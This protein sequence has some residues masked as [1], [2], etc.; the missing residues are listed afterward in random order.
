MGYVNL[1]A[2]ASLFKL[3]GGSACPL[4]G[5]GAPPPLFAAD[6]ALFLKPEAGFFGFTCP[7]FAGFL[8]YFVVSY[9][10]TESI[11]CCLLHDNRHDDYV[12]SVR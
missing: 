1:T 8:A 5:P 3:D 7:K 10:V 2:A 9:A 4:R 12:V 6:A 11:L